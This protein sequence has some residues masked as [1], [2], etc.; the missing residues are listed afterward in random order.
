M[1]MSVPRKIW[2]VLYPPLLLVGIYLLVYFGAMAL[3]N[4]AFREKYA[5]ID[6]F[7]ADY[8]IVVSLIALVVAGIFMFFIYRRDLF[9][10]TASYVYGKPL[11]FVLAV[12]LAILASH[13]LS[14]LIS[15]LNLDNILGSYAQAESNIF[16]AS[17]VIVIIRAVI[18]VPIA[19]E[20]T[21]RGLMFNR[22]NAWLGFWPA[23]LISSA[24]FGL[25]HMNLAQGIYA[26]IFAI[27]LCLLYDKFSNLWIPLAMHAGANAFALVLTYTGLTYPAQ[28]IYWAVCGV[29]LAASAGITFYLL[30][31]N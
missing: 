22:A 17:P 30:R 26:F 28:W 29:C 7:M 14:I 23:A 13:G 18:I 2:N 15:L 20:L 10:T 4:A 1:Y 25:Y 31:K 19:E 6:S 16:S 24:A 21:F 27:L 3:Y 5:D 9:H 8:S 11:I 12:V